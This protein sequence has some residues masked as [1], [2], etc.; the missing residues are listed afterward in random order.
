MF[1]GLKIQKTMN[2]IKFIHHFP[3]QESCEIYLKAYRENTSIYCKTC[4][5]FSKQYWFSGSK[6]F[7]CSKCRSRTSLKAG[8]V[9]SQVTCLYIPG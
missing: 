8:T 7:E 5:N 2:I 3:D 4:G 9:M 1:L 6:F